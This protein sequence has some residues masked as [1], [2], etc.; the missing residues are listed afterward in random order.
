MIGQR[1]RFQLTTTNHVNYLF[2]F[3][4]AQTLGLVSHSLNARLHRVL[5]SQYRAVHGSVDGYPGYDESFLAPSSDRFP[6][7]EGQAYAALFIM[8]VSGYGVFLMSNGYPEGPSF[9]YAQHGCE[10][11]DDYAYEEDE[12]EFAYDMEVLEI[13]RGFSALSDKQVTTFSVEV[14]RDKRTSS[15]EIRAI[16]TYQD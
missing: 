1:S 6:L 4:A 16:F 3:P 14:K 9:V 2:D 11:D 13:L 10:D 8:K 7:L 15:V 5:K 12:S